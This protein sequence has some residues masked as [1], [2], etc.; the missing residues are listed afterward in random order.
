MNKMKLAPMAH[1]IALLFFSPTAR[2]LPRMNAMINMASDRIESETNTPGTRCSKI[3]NIRSP[4]RVIIVMTSVRMMI[5]SVFMIVALPSFLLS[6]QMQ[7][8]FVRLPLLFLCASFCV[9]DGT[10]FP[11]RFIIFRFII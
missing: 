2:K 5:R 1:K 3:V 6:Y 4:N 8:C 10:R 11:I 7:Y 9:V